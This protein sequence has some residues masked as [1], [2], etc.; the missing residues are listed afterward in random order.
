MNHGI[1]NKRV[2]GAGGITERYRFHG[3]S[4]I[5]FIN[6]YYLKK[7]MVEVLYG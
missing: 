3:L 1:E 5:L 2:V 6:I 7:F 4:S